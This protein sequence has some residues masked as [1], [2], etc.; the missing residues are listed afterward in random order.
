MQVSSGVQLPLDYSYMIKNFDQMVP[1]TQTGSYTFVQSC[2]E[3]HGVYLLE[4][5]K[6]YV[7]VAFA[8]KPTDFKRYAVVLATQAHYHLNIRYVYAVRV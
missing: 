6:T 5:N 4:C 3:A 2:L 1:G 7:I 8:D